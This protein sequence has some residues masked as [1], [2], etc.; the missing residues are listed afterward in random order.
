M[1]SISVDIDLD[2]FDL[3]EILDELEDRYNSYRNKEQNQNKINAFIKKMKIDCS[4]EDENS[5]TSKN[6]IDELKINFIKEN[7]D[8]INLSDLEKLTKN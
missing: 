1:A 3:D 6:L 2:D 4:E 5:L 8:K 7:I